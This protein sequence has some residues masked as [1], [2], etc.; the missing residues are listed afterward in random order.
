[1]RQTTSSSTIAVHSA[2]MAV[3][4]SGRSSTS[5]AKSNSGGVFLYLDLRNGD[6]QDVSWETVSAFPGE[7][8]TLN[9]GESPNVARESTL[10]AILEAHVPERYSLSAKAC[11]GILNRALRRG[12]EL[13]DILMEALQE[14]LTLSTEK[15]VLPCKA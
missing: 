10:S 8:M 13:P 12:K 6:P 15:P 9:F 3:K 1:M 4:T 7:S 11:Q 5:S 14:V 2:A